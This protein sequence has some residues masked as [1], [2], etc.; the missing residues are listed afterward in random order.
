MEV[1]II[2]YADDC[3]NWNLE[4]CQCAKTEDNTANAL[5]SSF[6][7]DTSYELSNKI[8]QENLFANVLA[9][10][11]KQYPSKDGHVYFEINKLC[12]GMN[13]NDNKAMQSVDGI[14]Q[15]VKEE[16]C[17]MIYFYLLTK[18]KFFAFYLNE[19]WEKKKYI[20]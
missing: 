12:G 11:I 18:K 6:N 19:L 7:I 1:S 13:A 10:M 17:Y 16:Y 15:L 2:S 14:P 5:S 4:Q 3:A 20:E 8:E 9:K